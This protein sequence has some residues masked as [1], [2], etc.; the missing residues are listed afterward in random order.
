MADYKDYY[1]ILG[2]DRKADANTI[3]SAYRKLAKKYHPDVNKDHGAENR[4]KD[5]NE[6]YEVLSDPQKR[7]TY[8]QIGPDWQNFQGGFQ[9]GFGQHPFSS[10]SF[11]GEGFS[12]FFQQIFGNLGGF[13]GGPTRPMRGRDHTVTISLTL[14]QLLHAPFKKVLNLKD[15]HGSRKVEINLPRGIVKGSKLKLA[16]QGEPSEGGN[17]DLYIL[18][19]LKSDSRFTVDGADL[20]TTIS[21]PL[22]DAVLGCTVT[23]PTL[24]KDAKIKIPANTAQGTRIRLPEKGLP[25]RNKNQNGDLYVTVQ[26][27]MPGSL[28]DEQKEHWQALQKLAQKK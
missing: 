6:A 20:N 24:E 11:E 4:Y 2:V 15:A 18:V 3:K 22:W 10:T 5:I 8:D 7:A 23:V 19:D 27:T 16:G 12:D 17:G 13:R 14:D 9:S 21:L 25:K 1:Q 28:T 26:L